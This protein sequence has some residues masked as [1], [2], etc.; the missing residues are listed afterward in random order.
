MSGFKHAK[1]TYISVDGNNLSTF[2]DSSELNRT[3][4]THVVTT[5]GKNSHVHEGG[6]LDSTAKMS[7]TFDDGADGPGAVLNPLVGE[8]VTLVRRKIGT[9]SGLPQE[10]VDVIIKGYVETNP[11]A[12]MIKWS[13]DLQGSDDIDFTPQA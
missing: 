4:D 11:V 1:N 7:G 5:Y 12:D 2:T 3:A 8:K 9:G 6:L 13:C 10:T